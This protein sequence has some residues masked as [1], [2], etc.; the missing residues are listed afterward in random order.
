[1]NKKY[2]IGVDLS[3]QIFEAALVRQ[4]TLPEKWAK[5]PVKAFRNDQEEMAE[6][7]AWLEG[8]GITK[9]DIAGVCI[10]STGRLSW[11]WYDKVGDR[12]GPVSIVNPARSS[13]FA[14]V[15]GLRDKTD[16]IDAC[17]LGFY[18][19]R[20]TP[21]A[22]APMSRERLQLRELNRLHA[23]LEKER[24][25]H[26]NRLQDG[27]QTPLVRRSLKAMIS[28]LEK[29]IKALEAEMDR[30]L[31]EDESMRR[32]ARR[33]ETIPGI[34]HKTVRLLFAELGDLRRFT[35]KELIAYTGLYPKHFQSGSTI[36]KR[37]RLAKGS[38]HRVRK[39]LYMCAMAAVKYN[40]FMK[41]YS[42]RLIANG[43]SPKAAL[44]AVMRKLLLLAR[45]LVVSEKDFCP[46]FT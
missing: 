16:R 34:G 45:A 8:E 20:M 38:G 19:E 30:L 2:W 1:M 3:K 12:V 43:L 24:Q 5:C 40:P 4:G 23:V 21:A 6:F 9:R 44:G 28:T 27:P 17:V 18:G 29:Q 33:I 13:Y 42:R 14:K 46:N 22:T 39:I 31:E 36:E 25:S 10:E 15:M 7:L 11:Q 37:A 35:R 32:D 26:K 41:Q